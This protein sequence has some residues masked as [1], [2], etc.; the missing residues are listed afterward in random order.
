M[1]DRGVQELLRAKATLVI[2]QHDSTLTL[3]D[4]SGWT[5][6]LRPGGGKIREELAQGGPAEVESRWKGDRL[7]TV[8]RLDGGAELTE[9]LARDRKTGDLI[10]EV[11]FKAARMPRAIQLKRI[12]VMAD[13]AP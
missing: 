12:Y 13:S 11:E 3:K 1:E 4:D 6:E 2:E 5:R 8:R 7:V 9:R 10:L